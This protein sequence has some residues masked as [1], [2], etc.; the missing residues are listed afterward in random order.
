[1]T[2]FKQEFL[3][4]KCKLKDF[5]PTKAK[6]L[7]EELINKLSV[8]LKNYCKQ[9]NTNKKAIEDGQK[10]IDKLWEIYYC[11]IPLTNQDIWNAVNA[12]IES[13]KA[14]DPELNCIHIVVQFGLKKDKPGYLNFTI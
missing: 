12:N 8:K 1:M 14:I 13:L 11:C 10:T 9:P 6:R 5:N 4:E 7:T 3:N 2:P